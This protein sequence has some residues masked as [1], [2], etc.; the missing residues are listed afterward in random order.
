MFFKKGEGMSIEIIIVAVIIL[1][2]AIIL[3]AFFSGRAL[4]FS[5]DVNSCSFKGG[6]CASKCSED[7]GYYYAAAKCPEDGDSSHFTNCCIPVKAKS[8]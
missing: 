5:K 7:R 1:G 4:I 8:Q 3:I 2:V 6:F